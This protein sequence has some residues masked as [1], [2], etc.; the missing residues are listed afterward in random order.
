[1]G[2]PQL[3]PIQLGQLTSES[4]ELLPSLNAITHR[5][6]QWLRH[7]VAR[8]L[9]L[10]TP[11]ADVEVRP[12]LFPLLAAAVRLTAGAIG[13]GHRSEDRPLGQSRQLA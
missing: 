7:V 11:E 5:L 9:A 4:L 1:M 13:L 2:H 10:L 3:L 8:G 6:T 12:V